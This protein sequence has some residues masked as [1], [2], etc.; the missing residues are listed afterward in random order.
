M[1]DLTQDEWRKK[2]NE[3]ENPVIIDVRTPKEWEEGIVED[4]VL[5]NIMETD[6]FMEE[7]DK[8]DKDLSYFI[9]CRSGNRSGQACQYMDS[10]GFTKTYNLVGGMLEWKGELKDYTHEQ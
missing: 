6:H 1:K 2:L 8:M 5:I 9:Y 7:V 10:K 3:A 4:A